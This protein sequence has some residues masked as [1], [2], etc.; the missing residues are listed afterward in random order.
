M[1]SI[2]T[3]VFYDSAQRN[4]NIFFNHTLQNTSQTG[5]ENGGKDEIPALRRRDEGA[6]GKGGGEAGGVE[7][8]RRG[9]GEGTVSRINFIT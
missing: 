3:P 7:E 9:T 2:S 6:D 8:S 5:R 1:V 4:G